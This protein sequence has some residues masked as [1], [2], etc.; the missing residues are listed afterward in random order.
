M[1]VDFYFLTVVP[2]ERALPRICDKVLG[3]GGRL[4]VVAE[5]PLLAQLDSLLW[6]YE[7]DAFLPHGQEGQA[8]AEDQPVL[9]SAA[10]DASNGARKVALADG[11]WREEALA[12]DRIFYFFDNGRIDEARQAWRA[13]KDRPEVERRYWKQDEKGSWVEGP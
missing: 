10:L 5:G 1:L 3:T 2:L 12:F 13:L 9:L 7:R 4:L 8:G 6:S 11:I